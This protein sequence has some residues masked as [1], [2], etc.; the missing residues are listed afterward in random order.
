MC[1]HVCGVSVYLVRKTGVLRETEKRRKIDGGRKELLLWLPCCFKEGVGD[2]S[3]STLLLFF[4]CFPPRVFPSACSPGLERRH[5]TCLFFLSFR[6]QKY[7]LLLWDA[8]QWEGPSIGYAIHVHRILEVNL[9]ALCKIA[10][11]YH[12]GQ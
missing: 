11:Y 9:R 5:I 4:V 7:A 6:G 2:Q 3:V 1:R 10:Y 12:L 8:G